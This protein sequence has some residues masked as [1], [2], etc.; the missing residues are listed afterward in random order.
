[1]PFSNTESLPDFRQDP[2]AFRAFYERYKARVFNTVLGYVQ[3]RPEAEELTQDVFVE[4]HQSAHRFAG[5]AAVSTWVYR[6]AVNKALDFLRYQKRRKR[7][8]VLQRLFS[9]ETG[10]PFPDPPDFDHLGVQLER[11]DEARR[12]FAAIR[13]LP[14]AQQTAFILSYVEELPQVEVAEVMGLS[15][16]A[17]ESLLQRAKANLR[18]RLEKSA[19]DRRNENPKNV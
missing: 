7:F 13:R 3:S 8:A 6:I 16:K 5:Q 19:T 11:R 9:G 1:L 4:I 10:E 2:P 12:L 15:R 18:K 17:V 14:E